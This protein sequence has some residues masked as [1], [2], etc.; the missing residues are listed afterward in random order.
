MA[1]RVL[2]ADESHTIK[3]VFQL[4]LQDYAVEVRPVNIGLDVLEVA[5]KFEPDII[6]AD[7]LLQKKS[8][9][10]V[11]SEI[12]N[13]AQ[14]QNTPVILMWSGFMDLDQDKVQAS[15]ANAKLEKPFDVGSLRK[16]VQDHV[17]KTKTQRLSGFL[18]F[19]DRPE[20]DE[21]PKKAEVPPPV[22]QND[23]TGVWNME[24]FD[25]IDQ[26][27]PVA[28]TKESRDQDLDLIEATNEDP[29][30]T[31]KSLGQF[32]VKHDDTDV[33]IPLDYLVNE[34]DIEPPK[35]F[36]GAVDD[37]TQSKIL[38]WDT[39]P[40]APAAA[41]VMPPPPQPEIKKSEPTIPLEAIDQ[42]VREKATA[43]I[44]EVIWKVVPELASRIIERELKKLLAE[45]HES[46]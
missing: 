33:D 22:E 7:V 46:I 25:P 26:F 44:E 12:K 18:S 37:Q 43:M 31:Q 14:L 2:L 28:L 45:V 27:K 11:C 32:K 4:A 8:G 23:K 15:K 40:E 20:F 19:P 36:Y 34:E 39:E 35:N 42:L 17:S 30:W 13:D 16:I 6:F 5:R 21:A 10:D 3:K 38:H 29:A 41:V 9:Y 1:L 24:S